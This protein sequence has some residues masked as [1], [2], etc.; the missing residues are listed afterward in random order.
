MQENSANTN[1]PPELT[2]LSAYAKLHTP[3]S[4]N[5]NELIILFSWTGAKK[6]H[7]KHYLKLHQTTAPRARL[8]QL[9]TPP[10]IPVSSYAR[11]RA[12]A[13]P[14]VDYLLTFLAKPL[15]ESIREKILLHVLSSGGALTATQLLLALRRETYRPL[16]LAGFILDS[17]PDGGTYRQTHRSLVASLP[18]PA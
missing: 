8:L 18:R 1:S 15:P 5:P 12:H 4:P 14:A 7:I 13:K 9:E 17:A 10:W 3:P 16:R 6:Q 2:H 11:Q